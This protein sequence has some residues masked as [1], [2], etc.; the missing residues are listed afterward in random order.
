MARFSRRNLAPTV[1]PRWRASGRVGGCPWWGDAE[2]LAWRIRLGLRNPH[3]WLPRRRH[4]QH[5]LDRCMRCQKH[6]FE[7]MLPPP[8]PAP[9]SAQHLA[10][11]LQTAS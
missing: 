9:G 3:M 10:R 7:V 5:P 6:R 1:P 11:A 4:G 2:Q 8:E